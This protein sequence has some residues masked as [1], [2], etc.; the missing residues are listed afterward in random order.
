MATGTEGSTR[1]PAITKDVAAFPVQPNLADYDAARRD[2][3]WDQARQALA[4]LPG[5]RGLNI[6]YEA[7]D[8]HVAEGRGGKEA[9]RFVQADGGTRSLSYGDLAD[10]TNRFAAVLRSLGVGRGERVF[11]FLGRSPGLY[12]AVLGTFKNGSVFCP[13]FS[14][15]GPEPV[16]Q[17]LHLGAGRVL[18]TTKTL[19]RKKVAPLRDTLPELR[20][21]LL[22][23]ADGS[24]E[25]GTLDLARLLAGADPID[26]VAD[27]QPEDMALLHFTSGTTGTPKGAIHV[28]GAVAAHYAT[29]LYALDLHPDDIYW[30]TADPGW[31][32]GTSY[33]IIAPL[34]HGVTAIV[35]EEE[36]DAD[37]WY[38]I[39]AEQRVTVWYTAPTALRMLMKAGAERA[40]GHDLSALRFIASVGEPLN[41][42]AVVWGQDVLGLPVH[43]NWWQTETGGIMIANYPAMDIRP[44]SMGR[45]LPGIEAALVARDADGK[46]VLRD[47]QAVL[48]TE[49]D[50]MGELALRPGWPS[51]FRGYLNEEERYRRC[52]AGGWYLTGDLAKRDGDGYF[53]FVGRG[54]DVIKS[55]GH[56][57]GPFEV[58]SCLMEHPAVA[59][60]GV[61]GVPDPVAGE[62]VKAF[63]ELK[64]GNEPTE[65]LQLDII[66]F[67]RKRLGAA[68]APRLLDF[69]ATLPKT[70][71][72]KI[73][74]RLLKSR[75]LGLPEGDTSTLESPAG[76]AVTLKDQP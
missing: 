37:R 49:P 27:T 41:P 36:L 6:A 3:S 7:V 31:V 2:F 48:V 76:P 75:E 56:L 17:R 34:V 72:G 40:A 28:H 47:G 19:Y 45:P 5:G 24:P 67:A 74:R 44:G 57:I 69:T 66:G 62:V 68:V 12:V 29:G 53:W 43:D 58:E 42:E 39:L 70:R 23:D 20:H 61:I 26:A 38:R 18:V 11:S 33:G 51:M 65:E 35:D 73:L 55:S 71:S 64:P 25:P 21:V 10:Q 22:V 60:A 30:C 46:P 32:T 63:V 59:E 16:R 50:A 52:F 8:R 9:L 54:D 4:G 13:L 1:W 14:A 15:F